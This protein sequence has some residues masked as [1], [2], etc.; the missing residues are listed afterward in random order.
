MGLGLSVAY[1]VVKK[2][3]GKIFV[4]S[5]EGTGTTVHIYLPTTTTGG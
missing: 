5:Q 4:E 3:G 2:H 1:S